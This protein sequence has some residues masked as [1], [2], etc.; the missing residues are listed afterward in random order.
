MSELSSGAEATRTGRNVAS[1]VDPFLA[2]YR[3][4]GVTLQPCATALLP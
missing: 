4:S 2:G 3:N 1:F